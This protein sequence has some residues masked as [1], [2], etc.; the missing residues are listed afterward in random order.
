MSI[1]QLAETA[2]AMVAPGKGIIAIDEST[3][4]C[5]KRFAAVGIE[6]V[7]RSPLGVYAD[8]PETINHRFDRGNAEGLD[9]A[10]VVRGN[11]AQVEGILNN[12]LDNALR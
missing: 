6:M 10:V 1:E 5:G 3:A 2:Q 8:Q 12:L 9:Q 11:I 7:T 4:T